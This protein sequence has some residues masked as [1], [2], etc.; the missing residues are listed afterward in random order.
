MSSTLQDTYLVKGALASSPLFNGSNATGGVIG[1]FFHRSTWMAFGYNCFLIFPA[2]FLFA[3]GVL[4]FSLGL[5]LA[6]LV[7]GLPV[8]AALIMGARM[9]GG[10]GRSLTNAMLDT[11]IRKPLEGLRKPGIGGFIRA[12]LSDAAGWRAIGY[13]F[14]SFIISLIAFTF[15]LTFFAIGV[16]GT[17]YGVWYRYLPEQ[18]A[19]DGTWHRGSQLYP[20][21]FI[22]TPP[23]I[24]AYTV[25]SLL[26]FLFVWPA[27]NNGFAKLQGLLAATL[28]G[29]TAGSLRKHELEVHKVRVAEANVERMR[30][31]ERDLHDVTQAQLVAIAMKVG[32]AKE[33]LAAGESAEDILQTLDS[34][35]STSKNALTDLRGLVQG[36]HPAAL[37]D[38][39]AVALTTLSSTSAI[40]VNLELDI[41][42]DVAPAVEAVVY[43]SVAELLNNVA[44]HSGVTKADVV[45]YTRAADLV[46]V[47]R[48]QGRGGAQVRQRDSLHGTGLDGVVQRV[49][50]V[51]G[52]CRISSPEGG[53][54]IVE[55]VVPRM[56]KVV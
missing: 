43:Y 7:F 48:D 3:Y 4:V 33:R 42:D 9:A 14:V 8:F 13:F 54:T 38:G 50:S 55:V 19:S 34:A 17:T 32:D 35:H 27:I 45:V 16:G 39:L 12:G 10:V 23:R 18:Q 26:I 56:L 29:P 46:V 31:I 36:I 6:A 47:V 2:S 28:L 22:D 5:P 40:N 49:M 37:N 44:K 52:G 30:G 51:D 24:M 25:V 11:S 21:Y 53:P 15:S 41:T 20:D 1:K